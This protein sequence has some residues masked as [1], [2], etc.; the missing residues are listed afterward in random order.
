ML[1][2]AEQTTWGASGMAVH[3]REVILLTVRD[4]LCALPRA[5]VREILPLPRLWRPPGSPAALAGFANVAGRPLPVVALA[6][7]FGFEGEAEA[8][9]LYEHIISVADNARPLGLLVTRVLDLVTITE[10]PAPVE[11]GETLNGCVAGEL[12]LANGRLVHLLDVQK[13]L[14]AEERERLAGFARSAD[15]RLADWAMLP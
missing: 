4:L 8:A 13:V 15:E 10:E 11:N 3:D 1:S 9:G 6:R 2:N 12:R 5:A 14:L 7:L